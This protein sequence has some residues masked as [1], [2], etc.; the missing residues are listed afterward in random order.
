MSLRP[1]EDENYK[2]NEE[3]DDDESDE[4]YVPKD[5]ESKESEQ[6]AQKYKDS[7]LKNL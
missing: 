6:C 3:D 2:N 5:K 7:I 1:E 4:E